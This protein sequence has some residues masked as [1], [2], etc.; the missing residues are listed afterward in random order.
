MFS[1]ADHKVADL[2]PI[3][4]GCGTPSIHGLLWLID[5]G[6]PNYLLTGMILQVSNETNPGWLGYIV[7]RG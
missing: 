3:H 7:Y 6:D 2:S 5:W 4:R 1:T